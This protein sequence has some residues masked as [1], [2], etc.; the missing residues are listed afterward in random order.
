L[1]VSLEVARRGSPARRSSWGSRARRDSL[2]GLSRAVVPA[3][4]VGRP[5]NGAL[6]FRSVGSSPAATH[7][8]G[9]KTWVGDRIRGLESRRPPEIFR[10]GQGYSEL[11]LADVVLVRVA[12]PDHHLAEVPPIRQPDVRQAAIMDVAAVLG[13]IRLDGHRLAIEKLVRVSRWLNVR[14]STGFRG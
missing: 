6:S 13:S 14:D 5:D 12:V 10:D 4:L 11:D 7:C 1:Y 2:A 3:L 9:N 8:P